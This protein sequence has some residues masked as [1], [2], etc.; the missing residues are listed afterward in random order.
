[1]SSGGTKFSPFWKAIAVSRILEQPAFLEFFEAHPLQSMLCQIALLSVVAA[2][3][4]A[5]IGRFVPGALDAGVGKGIYVAGVVVILFF[6]TVYQWLLRSA[7]L[8]LEKGAFSLLTARS[9]SSSPREI[10]SALESVRETNEARLARLFE[11]LLRV[12]LIALALSVHFVAQKYGK[13]S[14]PPVW[15]EILARGLGN[16]FDVRSS[17]PIVATQES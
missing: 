14:P 3:A 17:G 8:P 6:E 15:A 2:S 7:T 11:P 12:G 16:D 13:I 9:P 10:R 5:L 4:G 1:M